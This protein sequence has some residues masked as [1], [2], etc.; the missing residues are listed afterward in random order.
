M[1]EFLTMGE[2]AMKKARLIEDKIKAGSYSDSGINLADSNLLAPVPN[3]PSCKD[4]YAFRQHV[5]T[6]RRNRGVDMIPEFDQFPI[7][8]FSN[9]NAMFGDKQEITLMPDHF[10]K[11]DYELEFAIIIGKGGKNILSK[12]ADQHIAG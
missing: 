1:N 11:L 7:F 12:D 8:Y 10:Y 3:P 5:A 4:A 2:S 9:H 6:A